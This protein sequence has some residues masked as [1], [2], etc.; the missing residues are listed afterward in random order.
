MEDMKNCGITENHDGIKACDPV[1]EEAV[2]FLDE[3]S[4]CH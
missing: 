3:V 2:V 1:K 4:V